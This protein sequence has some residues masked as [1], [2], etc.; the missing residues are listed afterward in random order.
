[1]IYEVTA[2]KEVLP[3]QVDFLIK[4]LKVLWIP[5]FNITV[6]IPWVEPVQKKFLK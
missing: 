6:K 4:Q 1:M 5:P 2:E 3:E